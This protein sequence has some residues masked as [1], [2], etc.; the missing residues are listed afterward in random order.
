[1]CCAWA[2][3]WPCFFLDTYLGVLCSA[4]WRASSP[5]TYCSTGVTLMTWT[6]YSELKTFHKTFVVIVLKRCFRHGTM[7]LES[8]LKTYYWLCR[9]TSCFR[10]HRNARAPSRRVGQREFLGRIY[11]Q[12]VTCKLIRSTWI[13]FLL[14]SMLEHLFIGLWLVSQG[15][16][17]RKA[18]GEVYGV[19]VAEWSW[20]SEK[21][22][23]NS[24][25][26]HSLA[27]SLVS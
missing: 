9:W 23:Q 16:G 22:Y 8:V 7:V 19:T 24:T 12:T 17:S 27:V 13:V 18:A 11:S 21:I 5:Q 20:L 15:L 6:I 2:N 1:M 4:S 14:L 3:L 10:L 26:T 25:G